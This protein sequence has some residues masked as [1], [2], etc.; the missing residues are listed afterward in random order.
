MP[1]LIDNILVDVRARLAV[2]QQR[3]SMADLRVMADGCPRASTSF[4]AAVRSR[5]F[6][7]IAEIKRKSPSS[8]PMDLSNVKHALDVYEE[9]SS[10][11]AISILTEE[12]HFGN[13]LKDL[14]D[15]RTRTAK[16]L[17]RKDFI[18]DDYQV[19]EARAHGADAILIMSGLHA[20]SPNRA[21]DLVA[22][23]KSLRMDVLYEVGMMSV[24]DLREHIR[25]IPPD[26]VIWGVNSRQ[27]K[28]RT[29]SPVQLRR[30]IGNIVGKEFAV[31][32]DVHA[33][34][35]GLLPRGRT[36]VAES[37]IKDAK[38]LRRLMD[39]QYSAALIGT[40]FLRE[41]VRVANVVREF[42][43]EAS[44]IVATAPV[45]PVAQPLTSSG[46]PSPTM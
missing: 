13:S 6:S 41:G 20:D 19:W 7:I 28:L 26:D 8:G 31:D 33:E 15:A 17:L 14:R 44:A 39:L 46:F 23:A 24:A 2:R 22:L 42:D 5:P 34:L 29:P 3:R 38:Y 12:D 10:V 16:P 21:A 9:A 1:S 30:R 36:A 40:A 43:A 25:A 35:R 27:F 11:S 37:G 4:S 45:K 32:T 18:V